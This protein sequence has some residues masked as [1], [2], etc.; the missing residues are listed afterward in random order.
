M[1]LLS[2]ARRAS[3]LRTNPLPAPHHHQFPKT[4]N[5]PSTLTLLKIATPPITGITGMGTFPWITPIANFHR[6]PQRN[7]LNSPNTLRLFIRTSHNRAIEATNPR[8]ARLL[9][10]KRK[11]ETLVPL[12]L[13]LG[14]TLLA[15]QRNLMSTKEIEYPTLR[16]RLRNCWNVRSFRRWMNWHLSRKY[17]QSW[18]K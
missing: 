9:E 11:A 7:H 5:P 12:Q 4:M 15:K 13:E 18:T 6:R 10:E 14:K 16:R 1:F 2:I 17:F 3:P 8:S